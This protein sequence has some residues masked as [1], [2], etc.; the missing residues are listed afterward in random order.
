MMELFLNKS[1]RFLS[2][3][4][5]NYFKEINWTNCNYEE[6]KTA[7]IYLPPLDIWGII[8]ENWDKTIYLKGRN[9]RKLKPIKIELQYLNIFN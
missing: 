5:K 2:L 6:K 1:I 4:G 3:I 9:E 7:S 8:M